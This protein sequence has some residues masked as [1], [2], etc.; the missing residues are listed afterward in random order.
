MTNKNVLQNIHLSVVCSSSTVGP[1]VSCF[2]VCNC[3][4][5]QIRDIKTDS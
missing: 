2:S 1:T 3:T 4:L 5:E